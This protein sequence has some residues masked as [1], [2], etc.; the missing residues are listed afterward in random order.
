MDGMGIIGTS[1]VGLVS[2]TFSRGAGS[3]M[4]GLTAPKFVCTFMLLMFALGIGNF[5]GT[6]LSI[7]LTFPEYIGAMNV[8]VIL[9]NIVDTIYHE[10]PMEEVNV[11][12]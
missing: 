4:G 10:F 3:V 9:H 5:V 8:A 7:R 1:V 12:G 2:A 11:V 6:K